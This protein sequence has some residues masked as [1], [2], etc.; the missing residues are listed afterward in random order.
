MTLEE[1]KKAFP[2][3][4]AKFPENIFIDRELVVVDDN[5]EDEDGEET[6]EFDSSVYNFIIYITTPTLK[7]IGESG[8]AELT[9]MLENFEHFSRF[10]ASEEDLFG[11]Y[12]NLDEEEISKAVFAMIEAIVS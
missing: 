9:E 12:A 2:A 7:I 11:V 6:E 1:I 8:L 5:Y 3:F 4:A 10:V